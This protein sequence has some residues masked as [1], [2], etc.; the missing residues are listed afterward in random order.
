MQYWLRCVVCQERNL[1]GPITNLQLS[2]V[3][4]VASEDAYLLQLLSKAGAVFHVRTNQ[5]QS[6]MV[7]HREHKFEQNPL[8]SL[9]S[10]LREQHK[11]ENTEPI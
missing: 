4:Q 9:A 5:P 10:M 2:R 8:T 6:L 11:W 7:S 1:I 3:D